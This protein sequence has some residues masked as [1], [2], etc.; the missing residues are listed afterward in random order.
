MFDS[1]KWWL[2]L[3][4]EKFEIVKEKAKKKKN[5]KSIN[6]FDILLKISF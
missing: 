1:Q 2:C 6:S 3:V 4:V 5:L